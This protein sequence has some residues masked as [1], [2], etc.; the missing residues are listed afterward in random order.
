MLR[1]HPVKMTQTSKQTAKRPD[2]GAAGLT[3]RC[4]FL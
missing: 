4:I 1:L 3:A 2:A